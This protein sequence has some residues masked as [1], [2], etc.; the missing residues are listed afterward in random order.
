MLFF[1]YFL[2]YFYKQFAKVLQNYQWE[3]N[4]SVTRNAIL[5]RANT[6]C[7][8]IQANGGIQD[9]K[10]IM[11]ESNNTNEIIDN[12]MGILS[13]HIEPGFGC[14][15]LVHELTIYKTGGLSA[16]ISES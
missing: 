5:D 7:S 12:E 3:F 10:N 14:G 4:N 6:I 2:I 1:Q 16:S 15:K 8:N 13:T 9:Y 11:D